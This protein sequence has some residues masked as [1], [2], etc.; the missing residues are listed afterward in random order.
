M[1]AIRSVPFNRPHLTGREYANIQ[2]A[3]ANRHL[4]GNGP[5]TVRCQSWLEARLGCVRALLTHSCTGALEL[6]AILSG[7]RPGDEVIVP[8]FTFVSTANAFALRGAVPVFVD[9]RPDTMNLDER[10]VEAA[11]TP[12]TRAIVAVHYAGVGC[13]M[14]AIADIA[15]RHRLLVIEDAAQGIVAARNGR[16]LGTFG[17]LSA[18]SF[19]ETKNVIAGEG[20]AL[21]INDVDF[22]ARA[23]IAWEKGTDRSRF[24]RGQ[25]DKYTWQDLGSSFQPS[26]ITAAFLWAQLED[27]DRITAKR[28]EIWRRYHEA[29]EALESRGLVGRPTVP[30]GCA[31]NAHLYYLLVRTGAVR[32]AVLADLAG[33]GVNAIFHYVPLHSSPA[34]RRF[35]RPAGPMTYTESVSERIIRLPLW[36]EMTAD[37]VSYVVEQVG[38]SVERRS[39]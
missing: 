5:F 4:A 1:S 15:A 37:H 25:V 9:I 28:L 20:G 27:A 16:P 19:H 7:V 8:S 21:V 29:F 32:T 18:L 14:G 13:E 6:A 24:L 30:D 36:V 39:A 12:K 10:L 11:V 17:T 3:V 22:A 38:R 31:H 23:E 2:A 35:G 34:G 33:A 26:E